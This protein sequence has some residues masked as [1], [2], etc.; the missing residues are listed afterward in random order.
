MTH[1]KSAI[2]KGVV[3]H[4][5]LRPFGHLLKYNIFYLLIDLEELSALDK[6]CRLLSVNKKNVMS[7]RTADFGAGDGQNLLTEIK[8][9]VASKAQ[10]APISRVRLLCIPRLFGYAFNPISTYFCYGEAEE[11]VAV[12]YEVRNT[13]GEKHH[14][15]V[16]VE[17][18][19]S[20]GILKHNCSKEMYVSPF[21]EMNCQYHFSVMPPAEKI[22]LS[23]NQ[24]QN[25]QPL[26]NAS[27]SGRRLEL[28]GNALTRQI[29][30]MP[31]NSLK[32]IVGIHWEAL[33]LWLRGLPLV[34]RVKKADVPAAL[35]SQKES[36]N[37]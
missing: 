13:F 21:I 33:K 2:Y 15:V 6:L 27:F 20:Q 22:V 17:G 28:T 10:T 19:T 32:V 14:Y 12:V 26:L 4:R 1:M 35:V 3:V 7:L 23:I 36:S 8:S 18:A 5:R 29:L 9:L 31:F 30:S 34:E 11:L 16:A 37:S 25:N 24:T